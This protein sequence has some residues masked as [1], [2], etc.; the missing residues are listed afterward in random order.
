[1]KWSERGSRSENSKWLYLLHTPPPPSS[2]LEYATMCMDNLR[3]MANMHKSAIILAGG[4]FNLPDIQWNNMSIAGNQNPSAVNETYLHTFQDLG[5]EQLVEFP[6]WYNPDNTLDLTLT[7]RPVL[8]QRCVAIPGLSDHAT[9]KLRPA[10]A[11]PPKRKILLWKRADMITLRHKIDD[12]AREL[13]TTHI[14]ATP[15][16]VLW[17]T[18]ASGI[19]NIMKDQIPSKWSSSCYAKSW[20]NVTIKSLSRRHKKALKKYRH[21]QRTKDLARMKKLRKV[22]CAECRKAYH[23]YL[24]GIIDPNACKSK[25]LYSY[26][27]SLKKDSSTVGPL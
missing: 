11:K 6:T 22:Q 10:I 18:F 26:L 2:D 23:Q 14:T 8:V 20:A 4:D 25:H 27:K 15:I 9:T 12:L 3:E 5:L 16:Q 19:Q 7:N 24:M 13:I 21:T 17:D 1:M